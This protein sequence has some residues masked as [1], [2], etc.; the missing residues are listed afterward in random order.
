[1]ASD[2]RELEILLLHRSDGDAHVGHSN[3]QDDPHFLGVARVS[4]AQ[5]WELLGFQEHEVTRRLRVR[6]GPRENPKASGTVIIKIT[7]R[8]V[9]GCAFSW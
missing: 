8:C 4:L 5:C 6:L 3:M 9:A 2:P 7:V 1:M